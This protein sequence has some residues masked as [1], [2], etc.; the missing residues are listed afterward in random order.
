MGA[1]EASGPAALAAPLPDVLCRWQGV[2]Q[3]TIVF[4]LASGSDG[5]AIRTGMNPGARYA[6]EIAKDGATRVQTSIGGVTL[7]GT[8]ASELGPL[9]PVKGDW[10]DPDIRTQHVKLAGVVG[11]QLSIEPTTPFQHAAR[12]KLLGCGDLTEHWNAQHGA[13]E[14]SSKRKEYYVA[15]AGTSQLSI[16]RADG[17]TLA[18]L[19][20]P[21]VQP[22]PTDPDEEWR[23]PVTGGG[24]PSG[25]GRIWGVFHY[26]GADFR[27]FVQ[28][29][30]LKVSN[31]GVFSLLEGD[32]NKEFAC[33]AELA[34]VAYDAD[35]QSKFPRIWPRV[36]TLA[37]G[38]PFSVDEV[39][40]AREQEVVPIFVAGVYFANSI[41][42]ARTDLQRCTPVVN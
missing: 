34:L 35:G 27:G 18:L 22:A 17:S 15:K 20:F 6:F 29:R 24:A 40:L 23:N 26:E 28:A 21:R 39:E 14:I 1:A 37:A 41:A 19:E 9:L 3:G 10:L 12:R 11:D 38:T 42:V 2:S 25:Q 16:F 36:G 13:L 7:W 30:G 8:M 32:P 33:A 31:L 5:D 4:D